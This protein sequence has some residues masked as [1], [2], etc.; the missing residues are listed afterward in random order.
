MD[1]VGAD[2]CCLACG[3]LC[4]RSGGCGCQA[5]PGPALPACDVAVSELAAADRLLMY[6]QRMLKSVRSSSDAPRGKGWLGSSME[7]FSRTRTSTM[8][9]AGMMS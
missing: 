3:R 4:L 6:L 2:G 7:S 1:A 9:R 5:G 8:R